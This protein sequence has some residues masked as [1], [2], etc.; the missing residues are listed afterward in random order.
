MIWDIISV[1]I[2]V[3][4]IARIKLTR[5][6]CKLTRKGKWKIVATMHHMI[7]LGGTTCVLQ[8]I[9]AQSSK[10]GT[11]PR[12]CYSKIKSTLR[13]TDETP[14]HAIVMKRVLVCL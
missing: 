5:F 14:H 7:C 6:K 3:E 11:P 12:T 1:A 9:C 13:G 4:N 8:L 2:L 10:E